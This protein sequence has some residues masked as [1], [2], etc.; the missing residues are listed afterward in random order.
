[1]IKFIVFYFMILL[2]VFSQE[3]IIVIDEQT[4]EKMLLGRH[5]RTAFL[6]SSF[7]EW[8]SEEYMYYKVSE[9]TLVSVKDEIHNTDI[10]IIMGT[11]C[12]DSKREVPHFY[13]II[14]FLEYDESKIDLI[15]VDRAKVG[16]SDE[17]DGL[18][19]KLVPTFIFYEN[20]SELGRIIETPMESLEIDLASILK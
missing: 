10:K 2:N 15:C 12:D 20:G 11:W 13:K 16:L 3:G 19:I 7:V 9:E 8:Y 18:D 14:D 1:M 5:S 17:V 6:D 4:D